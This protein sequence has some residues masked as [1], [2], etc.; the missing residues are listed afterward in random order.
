MFRRACRDGPRQGDLELH[1]HCRLRG[2]QVVLL[3]QIINWATSDT[4]ESLYLTFDIG[5]SK[6]CAV[7]VGTHS[8]CE[9]SQH[10]QHGKL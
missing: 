1:L 8:L 7:H 4:G 10:G 6:V 5:A 9:Q 2:A 3:Y